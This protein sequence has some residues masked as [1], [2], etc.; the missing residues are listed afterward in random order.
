MRKVPHKH[1]QHGKPSKVWIYR[2]PQGRP[3][4]V[5]YRFDLGP[6]DSGAPRNS[7]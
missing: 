3:L 1:R 4:M 7:H 2:D 6:G 5:L